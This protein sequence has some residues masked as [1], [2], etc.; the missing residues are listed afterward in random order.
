LASGASAA[1]FPVSRYARF[2][3]I[4]MNGSI[5]RLVDENVPPLFYLCN[6]AGFVDARPKIAA[7]GCAFAQNIAMSLECFQIVHAYDAKILT[8]KKLYLLER[9]NR[10]YDRKRISDRRFAWSIRKDPEL[11]VG[12]SLFHQKSNRI[13]FSRNLA[14]GYFCGRTI[15]YPAAQLAYTLGFRT[16]FMVGMDLKASAGRFYEQRQNAIPTR[17][18]E[19]FERFILPSFRFMAEKIVTR[20]NFR[21]FNLSPISR[22]PDSVMPKI[23]LETLDRLLGLS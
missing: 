5:L 15:A 6:D 17:L 13:G 8:G 22:L 2:P 4:A 21:G 10:Y 12:F 20:E 14:R 7:L 19:D 9:V 16:I 1:D 3:F 18:D 11:I 23:S